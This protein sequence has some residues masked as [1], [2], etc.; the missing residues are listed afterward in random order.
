MYFWDGTDAFPGSDRSPSTLKLLG[1]VPVVE[2]GKAEDLTVIETTDSSYKILV[3]YD[4]VAQGI[5]TL[6]EVPKNQ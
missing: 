2:G 4:R 3:V 6:F 5:P 1:E